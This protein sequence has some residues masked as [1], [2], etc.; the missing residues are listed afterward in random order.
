MGRKIKVLTVIGTRPEAIKLFPVIHALEARSSFESRVCITGQH[1]DL[2]GPVLHLA[3]IEP[4][5]RIASSTSSRSL[6]SLV[7][8]ICAAVGLV[9]DTEL[10]DWVIVQGDTASTLA[11]ALA[12]HHRRIPICHVEAG[13]RSGVILHPWP[14]K[15]YRRMVTMIANLHCAPTDGASKALLAVQ[16][17][18]KSVVVTGNTG[19]DALRWV[20]ARLV[21]EPHLAGRIVRIM[22]RFHGRKILAVTVHRRENLGPPAKAIGEALKVLAG[23]EGVAI[24]LSLHPDPDVQET[25]REALRGLDNV[26]LTDALTYPEFVHLLTISHIVLSDSGG[27]QEEAP[28]LGKPTLVLREKT[29]RAEGIASGGAKLVGTDSNRI[30]GEVRRLLGDRAAYAAMARVRTLYGDGCSAR[31]IVRALASHNREIDQKVAARKARLRS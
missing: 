21:A 30:I 29:E 6:D 7:G 9:L 8:E 12:A 25:L 24:I 13:L 18:E 27:I 15:A 22:A 26:L 19:I 23:D 10:P 3:R 28:A 4:D 17:P 16:T 20:R 11:S 1:R 2:V 31:R 5:H 14:G